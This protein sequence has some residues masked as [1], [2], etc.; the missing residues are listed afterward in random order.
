MWYVLKI[1]YCTPD[2]PETRTK[3]LGYPNLTDAQAVFDHLELSYQFN[4]PVRIKGGKMV[5]ATGVWMY[6][7]FKDHYAAALE[8]AASGTATLVGEAREIEIDL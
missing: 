5:K 7:S 6:E 8:A 2:A 4:E 3:M 1:D